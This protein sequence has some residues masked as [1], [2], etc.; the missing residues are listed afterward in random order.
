MT[1]KLIL[2]RNI[3]VFHG[4]LA[5]Q[6]TVVFFLFG[7]VMHAIGDSGRINVPNV[8]EIRVVA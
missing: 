3:L 4:F 1:A 5:R 6:H 8:A 2:E 7:M